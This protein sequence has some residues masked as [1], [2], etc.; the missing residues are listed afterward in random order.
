MSEENTQVNSNQTDT[1]VD[2]YESFKQHC[3]KYDISYQLDD[4]VK[5]Y[6]NTTLFCPAGMQQFKEMFNDE[7]VIDL[8]I[9]N[10]QSCIRVNDYDEI[11]YGTHL[12]YF[13]MI[14]L[15]SFRQM[16]LKQAI[17][18]WTDFIENQLNLKIDYVTIHPD[19]VEEWSNYYYDETST[20]KYNIK[21]DNECTWSDG[22]SKRAYCTEFFINDIEI[23]NIVNP[24]GDCIDAG[25]GLER[26]DMLVNKHKYVD[27]ATLFKEAIRKILESDYKPG[28]NG[29]GYVLRKLLRDLHKL[30]YSVDE[31]D[32]IYPYFRDEVTRQT[33]MK[34]KYLKMK[35]TKKGRNKTKEWWFDTQGVDLDLLKLDLDEITPP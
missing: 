2:I 22:S 33:N 32:I 14:G 30:D 4:K 1:N 8:T 7:G 26:L 21:E 17:D 13:N 15:F 25:F 12:I 18:F 35:D 27:K 23:G 31:N 6:D 5:A 19:K 29:Q 28:S 9:G 3:K 11:G 34:D 16:S 24:G 20:P 10:V